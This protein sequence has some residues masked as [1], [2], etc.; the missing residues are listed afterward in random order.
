MGT[1]VGETPDINKVVN[2]LSIKGIP[3]VVLLQ[4]VPSINTA[5]KLGSRLGLPFA[6]FST[7]NPTSKYGLSIIARFPLSEPKLLKQDGYAS[8]KAVMDFKSGAILLCSVHLVRIKPLPIEKHGTLLTSKEYIK[9]LLSEVFKDNARSRAVEILLPWLNS[10]SVEE[11][12]IGGDFNTFPF[13]K[14]IRKMNASYDDSLWPS[15]NYL[16]ATYPEVSFP[17][18]PRIDYIFY[19]QNLGCDSASVIK[20]SA[21]DHYPVWAMIEI[22]VQQKAQ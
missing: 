4:E 10:E 6:A 3:D 9:I 16:T 14:A 19:S 2:I 5:H 8:I 13:S 12:I 7:Y 18:K 11:M 1:I 20:D 15:L 22:P 21:G 17:I